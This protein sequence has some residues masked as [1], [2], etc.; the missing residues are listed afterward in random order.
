L[1]P[2]PEKVADRDP[3]VPDVVSSWSAMPMDERYF[4]AVS[5]LDDRLVIE[6]SAEN[7]CSPVMAWTATRRVADV[8]VTSELVREVED[9]VLTWVAAVSTG[10]TEETPSYAASEPDMPA[11]APIVNV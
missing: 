1:A 9:D 2:L 6:G 8:A 11:P 7:V 5:A 10:F 4:P 3:V